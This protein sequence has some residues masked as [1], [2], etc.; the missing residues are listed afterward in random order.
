[1][2]RNI[3]KAGNLKKTYYYLKKNGMKSA[4]YAAR[5][6]IMRETREDYRYEAP[7]AEELAKQKRAGEQFHCSFSILVP[8]YETAPEYLAAMIDSVLG[9]S[10]GRF[11]L[12]I[13]DASLSHKVE[14]TVEKYTDKRIKYIRL[15]ENKGISENTNKALEYAKGDYVGL[16]DHDDVLTPDALYE[17]AKA[18][19]EAEKR[20]ITA[21]MLYSDEDK[22]N[23]ELTDFCEPHIKPDINI[24]LLL[25]NNYIC[26]FLVVKRELV[27]KL[28][29]RKAYD[30]A[31]DYDLILRCAGRLLYDRETCAGSGME[32]GREE[33]IHIPK[34]LYHWRCHSSSTAENP[35]S[36]RYAY[37]AGRGALE[38]FMRSRGWRGRVLDTLHLGFYK[39][40]YEE[41][42]FAQR[43][44]V[45]AVGG[46]LLDRRGKIAG[47]IYGKDGICP[48]ERLH[49]HFSGYMHRASLTQEAYA[50]SMSGILIRKELE[51]VFEEVFGFPYREGIMSEGIIYNKEVREKE[52]EG[53]KLE[54]EFGRRVRKMGYTMV[55][56][57]DYVIKI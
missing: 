9:Q 28:G 34:V 10:Y 15:G 14:T 32:R 42:I 47:G 30:G 51:E 57:P 38:D 25:S 21:W 39:I 3:F 37:E 53:R 26:H 55:W 6:R 46:R 12:I 13:A 11:R 49:R 19:E 22:G 40:E 1:M 31:Q 43:K 24:D 4:Y 41:S 17:M 8:A 29:F 56:M 7:T 5:E 20:G 50:L 27:R 16:L 2:G 33:I 35:E 18:I 48:Y 45:G 54:L 23:G 44:E 36:K 52:A